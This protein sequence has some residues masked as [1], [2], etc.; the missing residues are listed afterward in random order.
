MLRAV[1]FDL[2]ATL[3]DSGTAMD[4][5]AVAWARTRGH[6]DPDVVARWN[7]ISAR[8]YAR[9]QLREITF[10]EQRRERVREF[11]CADLSESEA[12][13][14]FAEYLALYEAGW[15]AFADAP[16]AL[17][18]VREEGLV[19][20]VLTNGEQTQQMKKLAHCG[21]TDAVDL[22]VASST[23]PFGKPHPIAFTE[24]LSRLG[25]AADEAVMVGD[26]LEHD[27]LAAEAV[28]IRAILVDRAGVHPEHPGERVSTLAAVRLP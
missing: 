21:L 28:G 6:V 18:R 27:I 4:A 3:V 16:D 15:T 12:D 25:I 14:H 5:A 24:T 17:A 19:I 8:N 23:L 20:A 1:I 26:H 10:A 22:L 7:D 2:D 13:A 9:H 11:L